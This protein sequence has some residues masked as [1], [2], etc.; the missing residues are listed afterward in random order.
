[1]RSAI[2]KV[3]KKFIALY[4]S[5]FGSGEYVKFIVISRSRTGSTLLINLLN[6]H[7]NICAEGEVFKFMNGDSQNKRWSEFFS[8][9]N[10]TS[11]AVGFKLFY[12][13]PI[14]SNDNSVW[15][16]IVKN[17]DVKIIHL[18]RNQM[19]ETYVSKLIAEKTNNWSQ[20]GG[21]AKSLAEKSVN[22]D[23]KECIKEFEQI[24]SWEND[25]RSMFGNHPFFELSY[26]ELIGKREMMMNEV[27]N[28][29]D[30][31]KFNFKS[32]LK[33]QNPEN[34]SKLI[35]NFK[36]LETALTNTQYEYLLKEE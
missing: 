34:L 33:K 30:V 14:D 7:P 11:K 35:L 25:T 5:I 29:L 28:F 32:K 3:I 24:A 21:K 13:H 16:E 19:L 22:V 10:K 6:S 20:R 17:T 12:Y 4:N 27:S 23:I 15:D 26:E 1:M 8:K 9:K 31:K 2:K 18:V 36:E